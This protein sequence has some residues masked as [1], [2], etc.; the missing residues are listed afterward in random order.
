M[1]CAQ[2]NRAEPRDK[3]C[4][5]LR[6]APTNSTHQTGHWRDT[7]DCRKGWAL[8]RAREG[9]LRVFGEFLL[10]P[11]A[12][13]A[14]GSWGSRSASGDGVGGRLH[15]RRSHRSPC[16]LG[17][18]CVAWIASHGHPTQ[19][20][21]DVTGRERTMGLLWTLGQNVVSIIY[22]TE[23]FILTPPDLQPYTVS[24]TELPVARARRRHG[25]MQHAPPIALALANHLGSKKIAI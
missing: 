11:I 25:I 22:N 23:V 7:G 14:R 18:A 15:A 10:R 13:S 9:A 1:L 19:V 24:V 12:P 5:W 6:T 17:E 2:S 21:K 3:R 4:L 16:S 20:S 8:K